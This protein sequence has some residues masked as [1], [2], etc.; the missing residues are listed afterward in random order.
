MN[1]NYK[2][3]CFKDAKTSETVCTLIVEFH[4][5]ENYWS[6]LDMNSPVYKTYEFMIECALYGINEGQTHFDCYE[7]DDGKPLAFWAL[8]DKAI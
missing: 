8:T 7:G 1:D 4:E 3:L 6:V 5:N 2:T